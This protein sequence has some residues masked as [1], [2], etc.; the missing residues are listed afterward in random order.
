MVSTV[1][2][3]HQPDKRL[4]AVCGLFCPSCTI[5]IATTEEPERLKLIADRRNLP[6]D[7][8]RCYGCRVSIR[9][10]FCETCKMSECS[11]N[12][13]I[14]FC[15][16]CKEFPCD[17]LKRFQAARPHRIELWQAQKQIYESGYEMW[18][19]DML[20]HYSCPVCGTINSA[21]DL[22]C[23]NCGETPSCPYVKIHQQK[24]IHYVKNMEF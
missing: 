17:D 14:D 9:Y 8:V 6:I 1:K 10:P 18:Y 22:S 16:E 7:K 20:K 23:R 5:Y 24:I 12:K 13:E 11:K 3:F 19:I 15:V 2:T 21:Y 4:A